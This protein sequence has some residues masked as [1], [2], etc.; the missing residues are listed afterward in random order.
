[1]GMGMGMG[2]GI[3]C[4]NFTAPVSHWVCGGS[5]SSAGQPA[6]RATDVL[7][8]SGRVAGRCWTFSHPI[9]LP[10]TQISQWEK[11]LLKEN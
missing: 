5:E 3:V 2:M 8:R 7:G 6:T 1:M 4:G 11:C 10:Q 9:P